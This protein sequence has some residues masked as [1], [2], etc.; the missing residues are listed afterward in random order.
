MLKLKYNINVPRLLYMSM[1][2]W[3]QCC[4]VS[5]VVTQVVIYS[6]DEN[7]LYTLN[8]SKLQSTIQHSRKADKT[9]TQTR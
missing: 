6:Q 1:Y 9:L 8:N 2:A 3:W 4:D 5:G 7:I